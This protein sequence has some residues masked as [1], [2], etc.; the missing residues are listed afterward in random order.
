MLENVSVNENLFNA[1]RE[2]WQISHWQRQIQTED[3][4]VFTDS[5][6]TRKK[7]LQKQWGNITAHLKFS[8][9]I[10]KLSLESENKLQTEAQD[11][12]TK[13]APIK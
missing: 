9:C 8:L 10:D 11:F 1:L 6:Q 7:H 3:S 2:K 4:G 13:D 12:T 5:N